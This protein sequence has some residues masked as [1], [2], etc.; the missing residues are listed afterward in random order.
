MRTLPDRKPLEIT[1]TGLIIASMDGGHID[2]SISAFKYMKKYCSPNIGAI[3][4]MLKVCGRNDMFFKAKELFEE[5]KVADSD[6]T[7]VPDGYTYSMM[8]EASAS[9]QQWEYFEYVYR[10]MV[11]S[12]FKLDQEKHGYLLLES[13][14]AGKVSYM[15]TGSCCFSFYQMTRVS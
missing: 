2:D 5:I 15:N 8:L 10:E 1:F 14:R 3:N 12:G 11:L 9:A 4:A 6:S 7:L 13:S